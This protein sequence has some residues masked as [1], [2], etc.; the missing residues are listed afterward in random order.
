MTPDASA[1]RGIALRFEF[2]NR[3][4]DFHDHR[5]A[6]DV[7]WHGLSQVLFRD[8]HLDRLAIQ[9]AESSIARDAG[10]VRKLAAKPVFSG[11]RLFDRGRS[12][13]LGISISASR[14]TLPKLT[15]TIARFLGCYALAYT[16]F[17]GY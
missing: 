11:A 9:A 14:P 13:G 2:E 3:A 17:L 6:V 10:R 1:W 5:Y 16:H 4:N 15:L 8:I 7:A 12:E